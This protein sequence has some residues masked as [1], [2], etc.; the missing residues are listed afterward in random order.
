MEKRNDMK[1]P[2]DVKPIYADEA[3]VNSNVKINIEKGDDG[4]DI[5]R[6]AGKVEILFFDQFTNSI[7]SRV[8]IDPFTAKVLSQ[9]L[10]KNADNV[11]A[12]MEK[13]GVPEE[14]KKKIEE[15]K[16]MQ[17]KG[18]TPTFNTYIG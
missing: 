12:E 9:I 2:I 14:V 7:C 3:N 15:R 16:E 17:Q 1:M 10:Q 5:I 8:V 4:K 6:K 11:I 13:E 18:E